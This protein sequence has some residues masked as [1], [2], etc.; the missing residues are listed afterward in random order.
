MNGVHEFMVSRHGYF[1]NSADPAAYERH[2]GPRWYAFE[3]GGVHFVVLDWHTWELGLDD[4]QQEAWLRADLDALGDV[5]AVGA[6]GARPAA[7]AFFERVAR[8][9]V[10]T[11]SGHWHTS[12]VVDVE[13]SGTSTR[14][15][16]S[17]PGSTTPA[18]LP[19]ATWDGDAISL[20]S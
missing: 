12:R 17:S 19:L 14:P 20:D 11:F 9:P 4:E 3:Y 18:R 6:A 13:A 16:R 15:T 5:V 10:A 8:P 2:V 1:V 7:A